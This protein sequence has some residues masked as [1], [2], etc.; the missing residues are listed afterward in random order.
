MLDKFLVALLVLGT[1]GAVVW[2]IYRKVMNVV[3]AVKEAKDHFSK[4]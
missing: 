2:F 1:I 3:N 4:D